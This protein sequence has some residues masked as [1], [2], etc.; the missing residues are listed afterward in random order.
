MRH[1]RV[2][3]SDSQDH[4]V[5]THG[6]HD[7]QTG[8]FLVEPGE[9]II[10]FLPRGLVRFQTY[11][12][13][14]QFPLPA[15]GTARV[16][17]SRG[18]SRRMREAQV[19]PADSQG[20]ESQGRVDGG[21]SEAVAADQVSVRQEAGGMEGVDVGAED[22]LVVVELAVGDEDLGAWGGGEGEGADRGGA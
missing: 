14:V 18:E 9:A 19:K 21:Q 16:F 15:D 11:L 3:L 20:D 4:V 2:P 7:A 1:V 10:P 13:V 12:L 22:E 5:A 6:A 8:P 17:H